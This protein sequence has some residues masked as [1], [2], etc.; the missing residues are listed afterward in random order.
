MRIAAFGCLLILVCATAGPGSAAPDAGAP[1]AGTGPVAA[2]DQLC[3]GLTA[4]TKDKKKRRVFA[5][6]YR[7]EKDRGKWME[8]REDAKLKRAVDAD[9][10]AEVAEVWAR[11]DSATAVELTFISGSGDWAHSVGYCY[12]PDGVLARTESDLHTF[13]TGDEVDEGVSFRRTRWFD[14]RGRQIKATS[15]TRGLESQKRQPKRQFMKQDE[16]IYRRVTALP[17]ASLLGEAP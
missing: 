2:I 13:Q 14:P 11:E 4:L 17:F 10:V 8:Y 15:E 12:R 9:K 6:V 16:P 5:L 7:S 1:D 3:T